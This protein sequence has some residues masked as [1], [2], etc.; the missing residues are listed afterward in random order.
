MKKPLLIL[1]LAVWLAFGAFLLISVGTFKPAPK[2]PPPGY[3][4]VT[5][6]KQYR[7]KT[8]EGY[9]DNV[10]AEDSCKEAMASAWEF[11]DYAKA[12]DARRKDYEALDEKLKTW[13]RVPD[14]PPQP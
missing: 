11:Y 13:N 1:L 9:I 5:D 12:A 8:P 10:T 2:T 7:W 3:V 14:C 4:I 6:G